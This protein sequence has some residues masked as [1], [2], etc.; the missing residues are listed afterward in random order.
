MEISLP[1]L[2][3][4]VEECVVRAIRVIENSRI[5]D[6]FCFRGL[7]V[8]CLY[9]EEREDLKFPI[10]HSQKIVFVLSPMG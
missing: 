7:N 6:R 10:G 3:S 9:E 5:C 8:Q 1:R 2:F 4:H